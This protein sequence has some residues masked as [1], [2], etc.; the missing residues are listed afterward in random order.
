MTPFFFPSSIPAR[1]RSFTGAPF[2]ERPGRVIVRHASQAIYVAN[3]YRS[4]TMNAM[5]TEKW[6]E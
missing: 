4:G 6:N 1:R 3:F 5:R 2:E